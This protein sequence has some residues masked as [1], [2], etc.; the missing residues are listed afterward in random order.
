[1]RRKACRCEQHHY[2]AEILDHRR[3]KGELTAVC[4]QCSLL[5]GYR[6]DWPAASVLD[7]VNFLARV[8]VP[9]TW[10]SLQTLILKFLLSMFYLSN[11][12]ETKSPCSSASHL[13][14]LQEHFLLWRDFRAAPVILQVVS[15]L[16][17]PRQSGHSR[18]GKLGGSFCVAML[19]FLSSFQTNIWTLR[20]QGPSIGRASLFSSLSSNIVFFFSILG[21]SWTVINRRMNEWMQ[22]KIKKN[23]LKINI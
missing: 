18:H 4:M 11:T 8:A 17:L 15:R 10:G 6:C 22:K 9:L 14:V 3:G 1:M 20:T 7:H 21:A 12:E 13:L 19:C 2:L 5:P 16:A 23:S